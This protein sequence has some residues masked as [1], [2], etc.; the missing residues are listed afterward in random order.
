MKA[1]FEL[2]TLTPRVARATAEEKTSDQSLQPFSKTLLAA[3]R[4]ILEVGTL[5]SGS[6]RAT[7]HQK[8]PS[9]D[10]KTIGNVAFGHAVQAPIH[11][12][13]PLSPQHVMLTQL[14][15]VTNPIVTQT[16]MTFEGLVD[17]PDT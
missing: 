5:S 16:E 11:S 12:L 6:S 14:T 13:Q 9:G 10:A 17:L 4:T 8:A 1:K 7:G 3:S 15:P 2:P